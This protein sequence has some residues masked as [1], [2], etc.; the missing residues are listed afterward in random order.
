LSLEG[1][2]N[3]SGRV[4]RS[5]YNVLMSA[6][7]D[8]EGTPVPD[9]DFQARELAF[10]DAVNDLAGATDT[11]GFGA[12]WAAAAQAGSG[13][14]AQQML[15]TPH[16]PKDA[17]EHEQALTDMLARIP[18]GWGRWIGC[19]RGWYPLIIS[20]DAQLR[21][22]LPHYKIHQ[23]KEKFGTLRY[24]WEGGE[25][26][27][28]PSD[29]QPLH[30]GAGAA[31]VDK[32]QWRKKH[33]AWRERADIY[34][35]TA[36]GRVHELDLERRLD[37]AT[38]LVEAAESAS[39]NIC[40]RCGEVGELCC[41]AAASPWYQTLCPACARE[42]EYMP[43]REWQAWWT[44]EEPH[45]QA[46]ERGRFITEHS[47]QR[48]L[49]ASVDRTVEIALTQA[50]CCH[51]QGAASAAA[52]QEWDI[53]FVGEDE[54]GDAFAAAL[55]ARYTDL[56]ED[57]TGLRTRGYYLDSGISERAREDLQAVGIRC[58]GARPEH[59]AGPVEAAE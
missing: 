8:T 27:C 34:G 26:V 55:H 38:K 15:N 53:V 41:S 12:A 3:N 59:R 43:R 21:E 48:V 31:D 45:F 39:S 49:V 29:P 37:L 16:T 50:V 9:A 14:D 17:G 28:A 22:L 24:Y 32:A 23:I 51:T 30:P 56:P 6:V 54:V 4:S 46:R 2:A 20:T 52:A 58:W 57:E 35:A 25:D 19:E 11:E 5:H 36:E 40:E 10:V 1:T 13:L 7:D 44:L 33:D 47:G 42:R 18:D